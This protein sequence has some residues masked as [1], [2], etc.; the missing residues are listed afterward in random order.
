MAIL[1]LE[2]PKGFIDQLGSYLSKYI[3]F[4]ILQNS[5]KNLNNFTQ[6]YS[7]IITSHLLYFKR[8]IYL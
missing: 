5:L 2:N 1:A 3:L 6:D 7:F 8:N 4:G